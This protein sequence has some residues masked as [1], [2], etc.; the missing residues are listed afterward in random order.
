[1]KTYV[2]VQS[3]ISF[4]LSFYI[5]ALRK[6]SFMLFTKNRFFERT[7]EMFTKRDDETLPRM[8]IHHVDAG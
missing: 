3:E 7:R 5:I 8:V 6:F 1:M 4:L 2:R